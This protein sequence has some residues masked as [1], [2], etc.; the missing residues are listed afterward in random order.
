VRNAVYDNDIV[1]IEF[2]IQMPG[3]DRTYHAC[4]ASNHYHLLEP[5]NRCLLPTLKLCVEAQK[6]VNK[7]SMKV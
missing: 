5:K 2:G 4:A 1:A 6:L 3:D 7:S